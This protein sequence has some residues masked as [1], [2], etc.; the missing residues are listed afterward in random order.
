MNQKE[1]CQGMQLSLT[2]SLVSAYDVL[3]VMLIQCSL[4]DWDQMMWESVQSVA[5]MSVLY[6]SADVRLWSQFFSHSAQSK[7]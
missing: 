6:Q 4:T 7:H 3:L 1:S 5:L 2:L